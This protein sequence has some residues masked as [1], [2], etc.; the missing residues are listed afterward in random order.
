MAIKTGIAA[1]IGVKA[2]SVYGT[3]VTVDRFYE[4]LSEAVAIDIAKVDAPLLGG[5]RFLRNDRVKTFLR[6]AGGTIN[7]GPVMNKN[8]GLILQ[9]MLGQN[10][11]AQVGG[12]AEYTHTCIPDAAALQGKSMTV[13]IGRPGV[14][15][16]VRPF[17]FEG[18]KITEWELS[19][20]L[21]GPLN[22]STTWDF[23][24]VLTATA[25]ASASYVATQE[26]FVFTEGALTVGGASTPIKRLNIRGNNALATDRRFIG[27][28]KS[29]PLAAGIAEVSGQLDCEFTDLTAY[30]AWL[31]GTQAQLIATFTSPTL[32]PTTANPFK[33]TVTIPKVEYTGDTPQVGGPGVVMQ[34]R[35][36]RG[37]FDG[38]NPVITILL[39]TSDTAA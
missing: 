4:F 21:D 33:L 23:E 22:L 10:T 28:T 34:N 38:T 1:Q 20:D 14:D 11:V 15:G 9:H 19:C 31:A 18:G 30:A 27:N 29:E 16:T 26:M 37:L 32:I 35:P 6:G 13:Q 17:T 7:F 3:P 8:F 36:F 5:G 24:N 25:L 2:E 12:T 39:N